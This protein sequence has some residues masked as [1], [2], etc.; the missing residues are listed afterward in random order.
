MTWNS[1]LLSK[2]SIFNTTS[3]KYASD[4]E[5]RIIST[6]AM[7][8]LTRAEPPLIG[9]RKGVS[10]LRKVESSR[11]SSADGA[12]AAWP[13]ACVFISSSASQGVTTKATTSEMPMPIDELI[14][15]GLM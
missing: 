2:G 5:P 13:L 3:W 8:S 6:T 11:A 10:S 4:T 12:G 14:G 7:A 1:L 9:S 15:I